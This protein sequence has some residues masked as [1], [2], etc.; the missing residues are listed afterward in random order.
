MT[1]ADLN[2]DSE[3]DLAVPDANQSVVVYFGDGTGHFGPANTFAAG[4]VPTQVAAGDLDRD[5][6]PDL[7]V[8]GFGGASILLNDGQGGFGNFTTFPTDGPP[9]SYCA[10][11]L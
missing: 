2:V 5:G 10:W 9:G 3:Q 7:A 11:R 8:S 6:Y 4:D 1:V